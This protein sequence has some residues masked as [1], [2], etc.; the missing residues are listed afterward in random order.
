MKERNRRS[1]VGITLSR[2][3][4][5]IIFLIV[6]GILNIVAESLQAPIY[7]QIVLFLNA[8]LGL[9]VIITVFFLIGEIFGALRFPANLPAPLF[10]AIGAVFL[11]VFLIRL[12]GLVAAISG[13]GVFLLFEEFAFLIYPAVFLIVLIGGFIGIFTSAGDTGDG[14]GKNDEKKSDGTDRTWDDIGDDIRR[15]GE[16]IIRKIREEFRKG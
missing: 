7:Q 8:S 5:L 2:I 10:N 6:L 9:I 4:G 13:V 11:A 16:D 15:I 12:F 14:E 3:I 1:I